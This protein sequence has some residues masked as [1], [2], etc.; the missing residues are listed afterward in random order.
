MR[1]KEHSGIRIDFGNIGFRKSSAKIEY[2][3][4]GFTLNTVKDNPEGG[5]RFITLFGNN[6]TQVYIYA[7]DSILDYLKTELRKR[8]GCTWGDVEGIEIPELL[9]K[10]GQAN[11]RTVLLV[12]AFLTSSFQ[13]VAVASDTNF[14]QGS[15]KAREEYLKISQI[16]LFGK[17][18]G[19]NRRFSVASPDSAVTSYDPWE[20][21]YVSIPGNF[22]FIIT[23]SC[24]AN[25]D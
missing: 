11:I 3:L 17:V 5:S 12:F 20:P 18:D 15:V 21:G 19:K 1:F 24:H 13:G 25:Q 7:N 6:N 10:K 9:P 22:Y 8:S 16:N 4:K 23:S 2:D 14:E